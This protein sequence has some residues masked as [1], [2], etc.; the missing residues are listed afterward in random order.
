MVIPKQ[1]DRA[2]IMQMD[3]EGERKC[4]RHVWTEMTI[5]EQDLWNPKMPS[6][7]EFQFLKWQ[8]RKKS[9]K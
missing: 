5:T 7:V 8:G 9:W 4:E 3:T 2:T 1:F 6:E